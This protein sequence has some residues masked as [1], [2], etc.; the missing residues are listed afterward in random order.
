MYG[1]YVPTDIP[2]GACKIACW[3]RQLF[4]IVKF[5]VLLGQEENVSRVVV[6]STCQEKACSLANLMPTYIAFNF[7]GAIYLS[8]RVRSVFS[9]I[10]GLP[11]SSTLLGCQRGN[12]KIVS[13]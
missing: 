13:A 7:W 6:S 12:L 4:F 3:Q 1:L 2:T 10:F 9:D 11:T 5:G 8:T